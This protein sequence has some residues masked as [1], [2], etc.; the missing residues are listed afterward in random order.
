MK[1]FHKRLFSIL[2]LGFCF[3]NLSCF[4]QQVSSR[5]SAR[6]VDS[7]ESLNNLFWEYNRKDLYKSLKIAKK[8]DSLANR[9]NNVDLRSISNY[10][11]SVIYQSLDIYDSALFYANNAIE[12]DSL[13]NN[14]KLLSKSLSRLGSIFEGLDDYS[15][16]IG[17]YYNALSLKEAINDTL[18]I[19]ITFFRLANIYNDN[20]E[21]KKATDFYLRANDIFIQLN[22]KRNIATTY[23]NL[24]VNYYY[25]DDTTKA[26]FYYEKAL[27]EYLIIGDKIGEATGYNN[28]GTI[29]EEKK[30]YIKALELYHKGLNI[31]RKLDDKSGISNS[32]T[33]I[34]SV[35]FNQNKLKEALENQKE[36]LKIA[37]SINSL[38]LQH[39]ILEKLVKI[40]EKNRNYKQALI[41]QKKFQLISDSLFNE[42]DAKL[43]AQIGMSYEFEKQ[44]KIR[45]L[46]RIAEKQDYEAN[47]SKAKITRRFLIL[48]L[49]AAI[50]IILL[51]LRFSIAIKRS[52]KHLS[53]KNEEITLQKQN[54]EVINKKLVQTKEELV[55]INT[56]KDRFF[57]IIA[58]DLKNPFNI[59]IGIT[60]ILASE[61]VKIKRKEEIQFLKDLHQVATEGYKLLQNLLEWARI[62]KGENRF[63]PEL[64]NIQSLVKE[65]TDL[66][67][68]MA[69]GKKIDLEVNIPQGTLAYGDKNMI[70][71]VLRNLI[72]NALKFT[73]RNG[74][75]VIGCDLKHNYLKLYVQDNGIGMNQDDL[76]KLF[77]IDTSFSNVGTEE[78][79]GTGLGLILCKGFVEQNGG[80]IWVESKVEEGSTFNFTVPLRPKPK[81]N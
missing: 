31:R 4:A 14:K 33:N 30:N 23:N 22:I 62:Q 75:V 48:F 49:L 64:I 28:L 46:K 37:K 76:K 3:S 42:K 50:F 16:A 12:I 61:E 9:I 71:T 11:L 66:L 79:S 57:S 51:Y 5:D 6:I 2:L 78:E 53:K 44:E 25:L 35:L 56:E 70:S 65:S 43:I 45:E 74:K 67:S 21:Y 39:N 26:K 52:H 27:K 15:R 69:A 1:K 36:A 58:H 40:E 38:H 10:N 29:E 13:S 72:S 73:N 34:G 54:L 17:L 63:F 47:L 32:L 55:N 81:K 20:K 68:H 24:G 8:A 19:G 77:R 59:M 18:G 80:K 41:Y 60:S 7:I